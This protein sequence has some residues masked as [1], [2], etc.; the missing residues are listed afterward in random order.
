VTQHHIVYGDELPTWA[1]VSIVLLVVTYWVRSVYGYLQDERSR[2]WLLVLE[3]LSGVLVLGALLRPSWVSERSTPLGARVAVLVDGSRRLDLKSEKGTRREAAASAVKTIK[4]HFAGARLAFFE[5]GNGVLRSL[6]NPGD[7]DSPLVPARGATGS[8]LTAALEEL[9]NQLGDK[10]SA[11]LLIT[12]GR[13]SRPAPD[14]DRE[15][16]L[17][18]GA[19]RGA[20]LHVVDVGGKTPRDVTVLSVESSGNAVAHQPFTIQVELGC[21]GDLDCSQVPVTVREYKRGVSANVLA[22]G[23]VNFAGAETARIAF[24]LTLERAGSRV[25]EV[26]A[27]TPKGDEVPENDTRM[28]TLQV[29]RDRLRVLHVAGR[30][31]YDVRALRQWLKSDASVDLVSFFILRTDTDDTNTTDDS[32]LALIP[33]PVDELFDEHLPSFD[34]VVL[35]DIDAERYR[36]SRYLD[37]LARY[38]EQ[39]GGLILVGGPSAFGGG[40]YAS[41]PLDRVLPVTLVRSERPFDTVEFVPRI[42]EAGRQAAMLSPLRALLGEALPSMPGANSL[43]PARNQSVVLWAHPSRTV[44]PVRTGGPPGAMPVLAVSE[45]KDGRIVALGVDGTHRLAFGRDAVKS[46]GRAYGAL[47]DGLLGW[48]IR[49]PRFEPT[50]GELAGECVAKHGAHARIA[51]GTMTSGEL[52]I[53]LERLDGNS[54]GRTRYRAAAREQT[55]VDVDLGTLASG[56][57]T[58]LVRLAE[59]PATRFDFAC[60]EGGAAWADTRP[61]HRRLAD[62][63]ALNHGKVVDPSDVRSLPI[64]PGTQVYESREVRPVLAVWIWALL[65]AVGL[66]SKWF[67]R[68]A[69]GYA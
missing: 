67:A 8:D 30:P 47:W 61:D 44:L 63:T 55:V 23:V 50:H 7:R 64:P 41:S 59:Q 36:L 54:T 24:E 2:P 11:I 48:A 28:L 69:A 32:E 18:P 6:G 10:P 38:V 57:Y 26:S 60:E 14:A 15:A 1:L 29:L 13:L 37:N 25:I 17:L 43:G 45:A 46:G 35:E 31:T 5:F 39:G 49:D 27:R 21:F 9:G 51:L 19:L 34:V 22:N 12:D 4:S 56:A 52:T 68:R 20:A 62:L 33:F 3:L 42:T 53:D 16:F 65:A 66:G 40:A 58:A